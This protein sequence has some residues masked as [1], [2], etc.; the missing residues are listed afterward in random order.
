MNDPDFRVHRIALPP[1]GRLVPAT[2]QFNGRGGVRGAPIRRRIFESP[3][4]EPTT[5][6]EHAAAVQWL[7]G[8]HLLFFYW[9]GGAYTAQR[10]ATA[11][12]AG[13]LGDAIRWMNRMSTLI[14][15]S[16][17]AMVTS[18][19]FSASL[20][21]DFIRPSMVRCRPDFS[22]KSAPD[23]IAMMIAY[24]EVKE[25]LNA[26]GF[27]VSAAQRHRIPPALVAA[28]SA[29]NQAM[30]TWLKEHHAIVARFLGRGATS[31]LDDEVQRMLGELAQN[32]TEGFD[33]ATYIRE[34]IRGADAQ[35]AYDAY[36]GVVRAEVTPQELA[37]T[38]ISVLDMVYR[39]LWP[40]IS[41]RHWS[42]MAAGDSLLHQ[43]ITELVVEEPVAL[44]A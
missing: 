5:D 33:K 3:Y 12:R 24:Q 23:H 30:A 39:H 43:T 6:E 20:Y 2:C 27:L 9:A 7:V 42:W 29:M 41:Y 35:V 19:R 38:L 40:G 18:A 1:A 25:A 44:A 16:V 15:G 37:A 4:L 17:G 14:H 8:H 28:N 11:I 32:A 22:A 31:L 10:A 21:A 13:A 34:V 26:A 36:F